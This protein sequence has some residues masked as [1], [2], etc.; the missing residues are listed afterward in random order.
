MI[1]YV[2][3][4][5]A[6][7]SFSEMLDSLTR[8]DSFS[9][10]IF[11]LLFVDTQRWEIWAKF[12][13]DGTGIFTRELLSDGYQRAV[14][15]NISLIKSLIS[16]DAIGSVALDHMQKLVSLSQ[17]YRFSI[18]FYRP[19]INADFYTF[20][21]T[22]PGR[23]AQCKRI[24]DTYMRT[25]SEGNSNIFYKDLSD[26][27]EISTMRMDAYTDTHHLKENGSVLVLQA[28]NKEINSALEWAK[29]NDKEE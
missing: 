15:N 4:D 24:F 6:V 19:P 16:C 21:K 9:D 7:S 10:V 2:T 8:V 12:S 23:Y 5:Q 28:L 22:K 17:Q 25:L 13:Q 14:K 27:A 26:Y 1:P 29:A 11:T 18:V 3:S 20:S